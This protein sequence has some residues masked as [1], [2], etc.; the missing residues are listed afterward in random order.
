MAPNEPTT[1][2]KSVYLV[3]SPIVEMPKNEPKKVATEY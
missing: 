3:R 1:Q 2:M